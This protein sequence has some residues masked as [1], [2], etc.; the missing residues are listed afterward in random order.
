MCSHA[1]CQPSSAGAAKSKRKP[2]GSAPTLSVE[3]AAAA[4]PAGLKL[5]LAPPV[6]LRSASAR[7]PNPPATPRPSPPYLPLCPTRTRPGWKTR[8]L[9]ATG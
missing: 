3:G 7:G 9:S 4:S 5:R 2:S 1:L 8:L 6:G